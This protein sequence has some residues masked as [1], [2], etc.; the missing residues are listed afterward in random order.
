LQSPCNHL[1]GQSRSNPQSVCRFGTRSME[2][3]WDAAEED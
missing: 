1:M 3:A 2:E